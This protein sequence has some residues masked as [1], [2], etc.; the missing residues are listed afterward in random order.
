MNKML[1]RNFLILMLI[2]IFSTIFSNISHDRSV[3]ANAKNII[4]Q[5]N[6]IVKCNSEEK[7]NTL[8]KKY[9]K[10]KRIDYDNKEM[11]DNNNILSV[12]LSEQEAE[13]LDKTQGI[14]VEEDTNVSG[15]KKKVVCT[16]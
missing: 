16:I 10:E 1:K 8:E 4:I 12:V 14:L 11:L 2:A 15:F 3:V 6:Y 13:E 5:T 7:K 9:L